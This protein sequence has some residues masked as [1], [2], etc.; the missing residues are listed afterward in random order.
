MANNTRSPDRIA[1]TIVKGTNGNKDFWCRIG[2]GWINKDSSITVKLNTF[3]VNSTINLQMPKQGE[4][5]E[6]S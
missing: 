4:E 2:A 3:P 1:Y 6:Q 5:H